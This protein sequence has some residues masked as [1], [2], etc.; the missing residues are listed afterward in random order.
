MGLRSSDELLYYYIFKNII[1]VNG[2]KNVL[3][4]KV[5]NQKQFLRIFEQQCRHIF[6][7]T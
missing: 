5:D 3:Y 7:Y 1:L 2:S 6:N 4:V